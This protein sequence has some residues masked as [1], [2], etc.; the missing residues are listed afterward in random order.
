MKPFGVLVC[1]GCGV[2]SG[3]RARVRVLPAGRL[4]KGDAAGSGALEAATRQTREVSVQLEWQ[5]DGVEGIDRQAAAPGEGVDVHRV[6]AD[7]PQH[8]RGLVV[9]AGHG[10]LHGRGG[11]RAAP[12]RL[13]AVT[14]TCPAPGCGGSV[15]AE[16]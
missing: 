5:Q 4:A 9:E 7:D 11:A 14:N 13:L 3:L 6:V 12:G 8:A 1:R 2:H 16:A 15:L 10:L